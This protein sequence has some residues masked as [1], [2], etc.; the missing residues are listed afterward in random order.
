MIRVAGA[1][2]QIKTINQT[3]AVIV[4]AVVADFRK[5]LGKGCG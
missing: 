5:C 3:V 1:I 4:E 2:L